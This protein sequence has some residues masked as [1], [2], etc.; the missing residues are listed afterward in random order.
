MMLRNGHT[1]VYTKYLINFLL[2][3]EYHVCDHFYIQIKH[4]T[5]IS[6][7]KKLLDLW[8]CEVYFTCS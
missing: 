7:K 2:I 1:L 8:S 4:K 6:K 5:K 3:Y